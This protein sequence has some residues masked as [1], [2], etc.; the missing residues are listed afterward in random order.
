MEDKHPGEMELEQRN[1][2]REDRMWDLLRGDP[3]GGSADFCSLAEPISR[4][5]GG[6]R[7]I[8]RAAEAMEASARWSVASANGYSGLRLSALLSFCTVSH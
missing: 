7:A 4:A 6:Q 8:Q 3:G 1:G 5:G 2:R